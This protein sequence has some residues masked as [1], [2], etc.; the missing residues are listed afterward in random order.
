[1]AQIALGIVEADDAQGER[2][3]GFFA[4]HGF[5]VERHRHPDHLLAR[6]SVRPLDLLLLGGEAEPARTLAALRRVRERYDLHRVCLPRQLAL[7]DAVAAGH[8]P[9][10]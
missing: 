9:E 4:D 7:M 6:L 2:L 8:T 10:L 5:A 1:M 3:T